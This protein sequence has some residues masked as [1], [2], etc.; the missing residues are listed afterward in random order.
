MIDVKVVYSFSDEDI[1][2]LTRFTGYVS[3]DSSPRQM[4]R[5]LA[6]FAAVGISQKLEGIVEAGKELDSLG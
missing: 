3:P 5:D 1:D 6:A 4:E 2:A